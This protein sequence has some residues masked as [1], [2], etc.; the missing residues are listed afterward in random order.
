MKLITASLA[1]TQSNFLLGDEI[2]IADYCVAIGNALIFQTLIDDKW[3]KQN[4]KLMDWF[5]RVAATPAFIKI[6][7][8]V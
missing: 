4:L 8:V 6:M 1:E 5:N 7:G 3:I 2:T